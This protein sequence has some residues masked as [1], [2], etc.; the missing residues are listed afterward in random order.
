[1][2]RLIRSDYLLQLLLKIKEKL[3]NYQS[4]MSQPID[5]KLRPANSLAD[6]K[7]PNSL[8][9]D[10]SDPLGGSDFKKSSTMK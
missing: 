1:M 2:I 3:I 5:R 9:D 10:F 7:G 4:T 8:K 6:Q